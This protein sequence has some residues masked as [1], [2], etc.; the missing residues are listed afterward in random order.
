DEVAAVYEAWRTAQAK[1][2]DLLTNEQE[3][4]RMVDLWSFQA[5]EIAS[6]NLTA[7]EDE[8][9]ETEKRVLSNAEKLY[10]AAMGAFDQ[11]YEGGASAEA[12]LRSAGKN[13]DE[14]GRYDDKF[15]EA[16]QQLASARA[17]L[18]DISATLRDYAEAINASPERLS[19]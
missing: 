2:D 11:L 4:L 6:A 17:I 13:L 19:E 7:G 12:A 1:L 18:A 5:K 15:N 9:L 3:R 16:A 14:L 10:A 8:K